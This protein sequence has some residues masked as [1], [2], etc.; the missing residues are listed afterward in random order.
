MRAVVDLRDFMRAVDLVA[1][2]VSPVGSAT[3][4]YVLLYTR[5]DRLYV[6]GQNGSSSSTIALSIPAKATV[7]GGVA[8]EVR[9]LWSALCE[10]VGLSGRLMM[11]V[12]D[13]GLLFNACGTKHFVS[14]IR[15]PIRLPELNVL[16]GRLHG[17]A[18]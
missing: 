12:V 1:G 3:S 17:R 16:R 8:V 4:S 18:E 13:D 10:C 14:T 15:S 7:L 2:Y 11:R 5:G 6:G 9:A